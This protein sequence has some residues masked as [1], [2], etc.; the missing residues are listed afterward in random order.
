M[1]YNWHITCDLLTGYYNENKGRLTLM[2]MTV[3]QAFTEA[4]NAEKSAENL[5]LGLEKNSALN[6]KSPLSGSC[7]PQKKPTTSMADNLAAA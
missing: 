2:G 4:I 6:Q 1:F 3:Q 5:Y 7:L